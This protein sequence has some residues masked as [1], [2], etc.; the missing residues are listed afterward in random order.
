MVE[1]ISV[2]GVLLFYVGWCLLVF[3]MLVVCFWFGA[4]VWFIVLFVF[5]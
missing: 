4:S 3:L 2:G 5:W 1:W